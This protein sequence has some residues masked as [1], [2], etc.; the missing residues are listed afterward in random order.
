M[1]TLTGKQKRQ[2]RALANTIDAQIQI[3]KNEISD[4][5]I[6]T[7]NKALTAH[8]LIKISVLKTVESP[9]LQVALDISAATNSTVVQTIGRVIVLYRQNLKKADHIKLVK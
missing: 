5:L 3:G 6:E 7:I 9:L 2:L 1:T 8:E 4:N